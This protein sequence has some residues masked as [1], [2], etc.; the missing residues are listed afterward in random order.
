MCF[1]PQPPGS[2]AGYLSDV[3]KAVA[4]AIDKGCEKCQPYNESF[5]QNPSFT[6]T[7]DEPKLV[8]YRASF[9]V[10]SAETTTRFQIADI[11]KS[12]VDETPVITIL[13]PEGNLELN[14]VRDC[15][16]I[17][18]E[19]P[20]DL[21]SYDDNTQGLTRDSGSAVGGLI[22]GVVIL[23]LIAAVLT[24]LLVLMLVF[25]YNRVLKSKNMPV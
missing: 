1:L 10:K 16:L 3:S 25:V 5:I 22:A 4:A 23:A 17:I 21:C 24:V 7:D 2:E 11:L 20:T 19:T 9:L 18:D 8:V 14:T 6:C 13:R 12:W 15:P